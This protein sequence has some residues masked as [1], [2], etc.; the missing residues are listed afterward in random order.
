MPKRTTR[1]VYSYDSV[2]HGTLWRAR[3]VSPSN[4]IVEKRGFLTKAEAEAWL[5]TEKSKLITGDW[6][7]PRK[8]TVTVGSLAPAWLDI[9]KR[10]LK[11][12]AYKPLETSWRLYVAPRWERVPLRRVVN[13]D[14]AAWL[15]E[16][17]R[18][19]SIVHRAYGVLN[20]ILK[21][22]VKDGRLGRNPATGVDS[23]PR[24]RT[25]RIRRYLTQEE[26]RRV[27]DASG[28]HRALV[29]TLGYCGLRWGEAAALKVADVDLDKR[30]ITVHRSAVEVHGEIHLSTPKTD[31]S[32][33]LVP[34][35]AIVVEALRAEITGRR[36]SDLV[37]PGPTGDYMR[38]V[39]SSAGSKS[40]W[41]TALKTAGIETMVLHDLRHTAA[42][43]AVNA[44]GNV[45]S[46]QRMLG[47][48]SAAMTL[49]R[50]A[51]LFDD[52][53]DRLLDQI[54]GADARDSH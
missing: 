5:T 39:R 42:S 24:R 48:A 29:L 28:A 52:G 46:V 17:D 51:D 8:S 36:K 38:R 19:P 43:I 12:S 25:R 34:L 2:K 9:K 31:A 44:G 32:T 35:P 4:R 18:S 1:N 3:Y 23:L 13:G 10:T 37:F 40:W 6:T 45:K 7:D 16:I 26:L 50:Y 15:S 14:I 49:D 21:Q 22:A 41:K 30:R 47:H 53:L 33:R 11:P 20:G 27:A 54:D